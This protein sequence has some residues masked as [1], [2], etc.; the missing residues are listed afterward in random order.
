MSRFF[1]PFPER[2]RVARAVAV[3]E[4]GSDKLLTISGSNDATHVKW[5]LSAT[6]LG[7]FR[8]PDT[9]YD[10]GGPGHSFNYSRCA[11]AV[12]DSTKMFLSCKPEEGYVGEVNIP[13]LVTATTIAN[14]GTLNTA[15]IS[16]N[17]VQV[18]N[19][20]TNLW[21]V[22]V[23]GMGMIGSEL[24]ITSYRFYDQG[25]VGSPVGYNRDTLHI[26]RDPTS[27]ATSDFDGYF[28]NRVYVNGTQTHVAGSFMGWVTPIPS[29]HQSSL[30]GTY[31]TGW[32]SSTERAGVHSASSGPSAMA[33]TPSG[34]TGENGNVDLTTLAKYYPITEAIDGRYDPVDDLYNA[35]LTNTI[36]THISECS[37]GLIVPGTR[38]YMV[39]G[40]SGGHV[41]GA[42]YGDA[43]YG[44]YKGHYPIVQSDISCFYWLFDIDELLSVKTG[45]ILP[46]D[47]MPYEW[48]NLSLPFQ[49]TFIT[50]PKGGTFDPST[51]KMYLG[52]ADCDNHG[53]TSSTP[54]I[55]CYDMSGFNA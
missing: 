2:T 29:E 43:P 25:D 8:V 26:V 9:E 45:A 50:P 49:G 40:K 5:D 46:K 7:A 48:G 14:I 15:T 21:G 22:Y 17:P 51:G 24:A 38:T 47:A 28:Q 27:L 10:G 55:I 32:S 35:S 12:R 39:I 16:Q 20:N 13:T 53:G 4:G 23:A 42:A 34:L 11:M 3:S 18:T 1:R 6:Y 52:M 33:F 31:L 41:Y 30:G 44:G 36:W 54:I 37:F 19:A